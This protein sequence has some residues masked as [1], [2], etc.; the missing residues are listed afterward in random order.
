M[1]TSLGLS[2][3]LLL[4]GILA[5]GPGCSGDNAGEAVAGSTSN[6]N[7]CRDDDDGEE[8]DLEDPVEDEDEGDDDGYEEYEEEEEG[9]VGKQLH[10]APLLHKAHAASSLRGLLADEEDEEEDEVDGEESDEDLPKSVTIKWH[11]VCGAQYSFD[12]TTKDDENIFPCIGADKI[13]KNKT[14]LK[15]KGKCTSA[16][17]DKRNPGLDNIREIR[18]C[19]TK[20]DWFDATCTVINYD[21]SSSIT[22]PNATS[23]DD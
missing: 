13:G 7:A 22:I 1:R 12:V 10:E 8:E 9:V 4:L 11:K 6:I 15:F 5:I 19:V 3:T 14:S 23:S 2:G 16:D 18:I 20:G 21:G 17:G